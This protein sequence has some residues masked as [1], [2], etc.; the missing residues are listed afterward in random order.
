MDFDTVTVADLRAEL[1]RL[2]P[3]RYIIAARVGVHPSPERGL[4]NSPQVERRYAPDGTQ[5]GNRTATAL[6]VSN[7][8]LDA[9]PEAMCRMLAMLS[10]RLAIE[11]RTR[12]GL[13]VV[14]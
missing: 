4:A 2:N 14:K 11:G 12:S 3:P 7:S 1:A 10:T 6:P 5:D 8:A 13:K 9:E